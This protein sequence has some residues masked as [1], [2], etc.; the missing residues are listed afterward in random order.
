MPLVDELL[1]AEEQPL[2]AATSPTNDSPAKESDPKEDQEEDDDEDPK[3][4]LADYHANKGDDG[5]DEDDDVDIERDEEEEENPAPTDSTAVALP[6]IDHAP[7]AKE[8]NPFETD[9]S[10]ATPPPH[11][12]Y[13]R[14]INH[15]DVLFHP[16]PPKLI[17]TW[18]EHRTSKHPPIE[19]SNGIKVYK[20][21]LVYVASIKWVAELPLN[22]GKVT[23]RF[24]SMLGIN[25][26]RMMVKPHKEQYEPQP[27]PS[28]P[29]H[30]ADQHEP[31]PDLSPRPTPT[32]PD[33][34]LQAQIQ[35]L[36]K[37]IRPVINH[38]K[39]WL[40][41]TK[42]AKRRGV[43]KQGRK[44]VK[45]S[46]GEPTA[47]KDPAFDG[48]FK[49]LLDDAMDYQRVEDAKDKDSTDLHEEVKERTDRK[50]D[51]TSTD[52]GTAELRDGNSDESA[53]PTT[54]FKDDETIAQ[55]LVAMSQDRA[56]QKSVEI[57]YSE[58]IARPKQKG[59]EIKESEDSARPKSTSTRSLLTLKPLPKIDPKDK[60]KK[61]LEEEA[62]SDDE[63]E[64]IDEVSRKFGQL[65]KD[66]ELAKKVQE[67]WEAKEERK[68]LAE[69]EAAKDALIQD[70]DDIQARIDADRILA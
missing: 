22:A 1:P 13:Q 6:A 36:K 25:Q 51:S 62:E 20:F 49:D 70:F 61:V 57:K 9:E 16:H 31:M 67:D 55:F 35:K 64:G 45:S 43:S 26:L 15:L 18:F 11:P 68:K 66:E 24:A 34:I 46:K 5:D 29:H 12:A 30:L 17:L 53:A 19:L 52:E 8:T 28:L 27:T 37:R 39:A 44:A 14:I 60:G 50:R 38:H 42:L 23:S 69:E 33:S 47:Y 56:K 65:T 63:S 32:I 21:N 58:D 54:I 2:P 3:E 4:D 10:A 48:D 59:V 7:S 40:K 41:A